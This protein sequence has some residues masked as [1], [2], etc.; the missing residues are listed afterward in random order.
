MNILLIIFKNTNIIS[1]VIEA[2]EKK[3][4]INN[5]TIDI[6]SNQN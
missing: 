1:Y 6:S 3:K 2:L 5:I 4:E